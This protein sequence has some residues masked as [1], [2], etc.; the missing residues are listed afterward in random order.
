MIFAQQKY[1]VHQFDILNKKY[2]RTK[3]QLALKK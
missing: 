3:L 2:T 1:K